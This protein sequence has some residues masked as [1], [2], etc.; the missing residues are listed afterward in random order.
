MILTKYMKKLVFLVLAAALLATGC[1]SIKVDRVETDTVTDYSGKWNDTDSRIVAQEL[2]QDMTTRPWAS[3]FT[4]A[5]GKKPAII[6]F[7]LY[8]MCALS[9]HIEV[10]PFIKA[11]ERE[12]INTATAK[13]VASAEEREQLRAERLDQQE[14]ASEET[15]KQLAHEYG[16]DYMLQGI[17]TTITDQIDGKK[18]IFY[19]VNLELINVESNEKAWIGNTEIKKIIKSKKIKG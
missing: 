11:I 6:I 3:E 8:H 10:V 2:M 19:Q 4:A 17:I 5:N 14:Y 18:A 16:A 7:S 13:I 1:K 15:A 12:V 9:E